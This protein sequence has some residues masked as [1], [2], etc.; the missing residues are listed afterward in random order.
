ME[1]VPPDLQRLIFGTAQLDDGRSLAHY[2][3]A[4]G[5]TL[6]LILDIRGGGAEGGVDDGDGDEGGGEAAGEDEKEEVEGKIKEHDWN[7]ETEKVE[8]GSGI[9]YP[10]ARGRSHPYDRIL[11]YPYLEAPIRQSMLSSY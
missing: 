8:H 1:G 4:L 11:S 3:V 6:L 7:C 10:S 5:S 2:R 9:S